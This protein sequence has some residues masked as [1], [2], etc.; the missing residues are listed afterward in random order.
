MTINKSIIEI[1]RI[2]DRLSS[3]YARLSWACDRI[4]WLARYHKVPQI[5]T[6]A[7]A[8]KATA[9]MDGTWYG[10]RLEETIILNYIKECCKC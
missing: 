8:T 9:V 7:L 1:N 10:D 2:L 4:A 3:N 6:D 5:L